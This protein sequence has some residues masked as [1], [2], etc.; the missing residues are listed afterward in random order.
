VKLKRFTG[1]EHLV[2]LIDLAPNIISELDMNNEDGEGEQPI[3][4]MEHLGRGSLHLL[5]RRMRQMRYA[6]EEML[7]KM[8]R[9]MEY[10]P[11]R[12]LWSIFLCRMYSR[13]PDI[14]EELK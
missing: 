9:G 5:R 7:S 6:N 3:M 14:N 13:P 11:N 4:V 2:Q 1:S 10:I 12:A 8:L